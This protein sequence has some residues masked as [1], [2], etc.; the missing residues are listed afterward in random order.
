MVSLPMIQKLKDSIMDADLIVENAY[1]LFEGYKVVNINQRYEM[2]AEEQKEESSKSKIEEIHMK[3]GKWSY[4]DL[5]RGT[6]NF[7]S[8]IVSPKKNKNWS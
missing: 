2:L 3:P 8:K 7:I 6:S 1:E 5:I 4:A